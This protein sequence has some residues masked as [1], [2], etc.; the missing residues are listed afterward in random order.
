MHSALSPPNTGVDERR[1]EK[2]ALLLNTRS[3]CLLRTE[4]IQSSLERFLTSV[5][6][7]LWS[8][9]GGSQEESLAKRK[10]EVEQGDSA[11]WEFE[12]VVARPSRELIFGGPVDRGSGVGEDGQAHCRVRQRQ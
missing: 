4:Q 5:D 1:F 7:E 2:K 8:S 9:Q 10:M 12:S 6:P 11:G 3:G